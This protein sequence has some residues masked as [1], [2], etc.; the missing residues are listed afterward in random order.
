MELIKQDKAILEEVYESLLQ[1]FEHALTNSWVLGELSFILQRTIKE[2]DVIIYRAFDNSY[3]Y[4]CLSSNVFYVD[5]KATLNKLQEA[6]NTYFG[7]ENKAL[8][9]QEQTEFETW[10]FKQCFSYEPEDEEL[11]FPECYISDFK[12]CKFIV[13]YE[14]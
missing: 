3:G 4:E 13:F 10:L 7:H 5:R 6:S 2:V 1:H 9:I 8:T 14:D 12:S 11:D